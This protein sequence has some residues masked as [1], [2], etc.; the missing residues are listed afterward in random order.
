MVMIRFGH[1]AV[2]LFVRNAN[3][4]TKSGKNF[5][6]IATPMVSIINI[7]GTITW[8]NRLVLGLVFDVNNLT[9]GGTK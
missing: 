4:R 9:L 6:Q 7:S 2:S 8:T 1:H 5:S 3:S